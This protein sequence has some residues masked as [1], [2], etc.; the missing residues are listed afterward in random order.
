[1]LEE[2][3]ERSHNRAQ[4]KLERFIQI[5]EAEKRQ[6]LE[7]I[8]RKAARGEYMIVVELYVL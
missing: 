8:R 4:D 1:M 6:K 3:H 2:I 7:K 5:K